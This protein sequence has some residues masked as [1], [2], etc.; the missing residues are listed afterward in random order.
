MKGGGGGGGWGGG[1]GSKSTVGIRNFNLRRSQVRKMGKI[2][3][4]PP[5]IYNDPRQQYKEFTVPLFLCKWM[6]YMSLLRVA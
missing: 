2:L 6:T 4:N 3:W 5:L 1:G